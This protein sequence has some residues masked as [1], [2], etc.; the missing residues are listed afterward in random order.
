MTAMLHPEAF[1]N[2]CNYVFSASGVAH[3][4]DIYDAAGRI[5]NY[6]AQETYDEYF[7]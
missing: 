6:L 3:S 2:L 1:V 4:G 7:D 5:A